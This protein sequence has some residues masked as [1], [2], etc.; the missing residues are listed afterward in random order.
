MVCAHLD[1]MVSLYLACKTEETRKSIVEFLAAT[2]EKNREEMKVGCIPLF[3][4]LCHPPGMGDA[5]A[6]IT[7]LQ[8]TSHNVTC[9]G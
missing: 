1:R 7:L 3:G 5:S 9:K 6:D 4:H 8:G 2:P